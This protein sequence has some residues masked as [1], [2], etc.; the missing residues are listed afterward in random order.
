MLLQISYRNGERR[1]INLHPSFFAGDA[2]NKRENISP[3]R[4]ADDLA[5]TLGRDPYKITITRGADIVVDK[6]YRSNNPK[7]LMPAAFP[8]DE[9]KVK[10]DLRRQLKNAPFI[11]HFKLGEPNPLVIK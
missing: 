7:E 3:E 11:Y 9:K 5:W 2:Q 10:K 8:I 4:K 1:N 6:T